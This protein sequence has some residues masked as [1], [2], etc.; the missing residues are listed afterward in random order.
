MG[1]KESIDGGVDSSRRNFLKSIVGTLTIAGVGLPISEILAG[2]IENKSIDEL[3]KI[4]ET[5]LEKKLE[6]T[7]FIDSL[8]IIVF[9]DL[10]TSLGKIDL[11]GKS[12]NNHYSSY[13]ST[14]LKIISKKIPNFG[15]V[16]KTIEKIGEHFPHEA[17]YALIGL[18]FI[19]SG[20]GKKSLEEFNHMWIEITEAV[21]ILSIVGWYAD[22]SVKTPKS[23]EIKLDIENNLGTDYDSLN[24]FDKYNKIQSHLSHILLF[25]PMEAPMRFFN[26]AQGNAVFTRKYLH[27][28]NILVDKMGD[29]FLGKNVN[30]ILKIVGIKSNII[31]ILINIGLTGDS[32]FSTD[33]NEKFKKEYKKELGSGLI[34]STMDITNTHG[35]D[36]APAFVGAIQSFGLKDSL[37]LYPGLFLQSLFMAISSSYFNSVR[38]GIDK[39][40]WFKLIRLSIKPIIYSFKNSFSSMF[41]LQTEDGKKGFPG[42]QNVLQKSFDFGRTLVQMGGRVFNPD[43]NLFPFEIRGILKEMEEEILGYTN[44]G[45]S[46]DNAL[47]KTFE[48]TEENILGDNTGL[49]STKILNELFSSY[50]RN[51]ASNLDLHNGIKNFLEE[52]TNIA[53]DKRQKLEEVLEISEKGERTEILEFVTKLEKYVDSSTGE[54]VGVIMAQGN[55]V[56]A[57]LSRLDS[58]E[59][60][61]KKLSNEKIDNAINEVSYK[62]NKNQFV[63]DLI[64]SLIFFIFSE[65]ADNWVGMMSLA[66]KL[67]KA[68]IFD[69]LLFEIGKGLNI[70]E[71]KKQLES[72]W[73]TTNVRGQFDNFI[74]CI[75]IA[76]GTQLKP[77]E[78]KKIEHK[79]TSL[80][81]IS[82]IMN[83]NGGGET[84]IGNAPHFIAL[85]EDLK[86]MLDLPGML[87]EQFNF[88]SLP[89]FS[90][91]WLMRFSASFLMAHNV[92]P[93]ITINLREKFGIE[94]GK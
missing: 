3:K 61:I 52:N 13:I 93:E 20:S 38:L 26:L 14:L 74:K 56:P 62:G 32:E 21:G 2:E 40:E 84:T 6:D 12:Y 63:R 19:R 85:V 30:E 89:K 60:I 1:F 17:L 64:Y 23:E 5:E 83:V 87:K 25:A 24:D 72:S 29:I 88:K 33:V 49:G 86:T 39:S 16:T 90:E 80:Q 71:I 76:R 73:L 46:L 36:V 47:M 69:D 50:L 10:V 57:L 53:D 9:V 78:L 70:S 41:Y 27:E 79:Y 18:N 44:E 11:P 65:F 48:S 34:S 58:I 37:V 15:E 82:I 91:H 66:K 35:L 4:S 43:L 67:S 45:L 7:K 68:Y 54:T 55:V 22:G 59:D 8:I 42:A 81:N 31:K 28:L 75:E 51:S 77:E 92:L 94:F